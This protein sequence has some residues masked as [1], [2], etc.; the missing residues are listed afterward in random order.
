MGRTPLSWALITVFYIIYYSLLAGF[1]AL[2]LFIFFQTIDDKE[3]RW[4][5]KSSI[6]GTSPALGIRPGQ[7]WELIDS[8]IIMFNKDSAKDTDEL[9]GWE[10]WV[11]RYKTFLEGYSKENKNA[12]ACTAE[13]E[14]TGDQ[15]CKFD[16]AQLGPCGKGNFGYDQG[17]PCVLVKLNKIYSLEH[18]YYNNTNDLPSGFPERVKNL[19]TTA[20]NDAENNQVW[21]DCNGE[22]TADVEG[23]GNLSYNPPRSGMP[24]V[25]FPFMNQK[26][27][28]PPLVAVQFN[29]VRP[30]QL[31]HVECRAWA[32]NIG[33]HKRDKIG[34]AHF[35]LMVHT[36]ATAK[37]LKGEL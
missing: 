17:K 6:I 31:L 16:L 3:P 11:K 8:S 26:G 25:Y 36:A 19:L 7:T 14:L 5:A 4:V 27:Y 13:T 10:G 18:E 28:L 32:K 12:V 1:W 29:N 34:R 37:A 22:N 24:A 9:A 35:E 2:M 15:F 21:V 30:G 23:M 20:K 33:Y